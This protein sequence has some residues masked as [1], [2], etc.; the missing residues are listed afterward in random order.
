MEDAGGNISRVDVPVMIVDGA[1]VGA[2]SLP[3]TDLVVPASG[4]PLSV[5]RTYDSRDGRDGDFG[6]GWTLDVTGMDVSVTRDQGLGWEQSPGRWSTTLQ[7]TAD[8]TVRITLPDGRRADR[9]SV[10]VG[11]RVYVRVGFGGA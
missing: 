7:P 4:V 2:F 1:Q 3:F 6:A 10:V 8:H 5:V 9:T 11:K